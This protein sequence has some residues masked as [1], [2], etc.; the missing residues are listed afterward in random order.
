MTP[1]AS[2]VLV[3]VLL[4][5]VLAVTRLSP[6]PA[7]GMFRS[8][9]A[10][11]AQH[12]AVNRQVVDSH[13][14]ARAG[15]KSRR[16]SIGMAI[17]AFARKYATGLKHPY[18]TGGTSPTSGWDCTYFAAYVWR[19]FGFDAV[20]GFSY[21]T[22]YFATSSLWL[23]P[24]SKTVSPRPGALVFEAGA[25]GTVANPGHVGVLV[26]VH[27]LLMVAAADSAQGTIY[28]V[29]RQVSGYKIPA[30]GW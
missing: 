23:S 20:P 4:A 11:L 18:M 15:H 10:Q 24:T 27:P 29:P 3:A 28:E 1:M 5:A 30:G 14:D 7:T 16:L 2:S 21:G 9:A 25:D 22:H 8:H 19:H 6:H 17:A 12:P 26:S 13:P